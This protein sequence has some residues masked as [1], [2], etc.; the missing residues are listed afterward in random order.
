MEHSIDPRRTRT[1]ADLVFDKLQDEIITLKILPG[2]KISEAE[3]AR[4]LGVSRQPVRD[5]FNRLD[6]LELL[7]VRPQRATVVRGFSMDGIENARFVRQAVE[8][9][10]VAQACRVWDHSRAAKLAENTALQADAITAGQ[11]ERFHELDYKFHQMI[12]RL[13]GNPLAFQVIEDCKRKMDRLC[14]LSL[15]KSEEVQTILEDHQ[16]IQR[17][18]AARSIEDV[19]AA[20]RSHLRRLDNTIREIHESHSEYFD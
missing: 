20:T 4:R 11:I 14:M 13:S 8:L 19:R 1:T 12:C 17:A 2:T 9:E 16:R 5:A 7:W 10:V 3:V 18:L 6:S 15:G